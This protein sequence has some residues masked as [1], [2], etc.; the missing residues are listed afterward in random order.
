MNKITKALLILLVY[1]VVI[2]GV[3]AYLYQDQ[4]NDMIQMAQNAITG[5]FG[6]ET[7][8]IPDNDEEID[9]E[10]VSISVDA[11]TAKT[12]F[13]FG[14]EF[15]PEGLKITATLDNGKTKTISP[16]QCRYVNIDTEKAGS[17]TVYVYYGNKSA[18]YNIT[19]ETRIIPTISAT[20]VFNM[21]PN[22]VYRVEAE[23]IDMSASGAKLASGASSFVANAA[24]GA[25][26]TSGN[27]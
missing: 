19:V 11:T 13:K 24:S 6:G 7:P 5:I 27:K 2:A 18:S 1:I 15:S 16:D 20:P 4:V 26:A 21:T 10:V 12:T 14:E 8:E 17:K 25:D 9:A 22:N 3:M 23:S